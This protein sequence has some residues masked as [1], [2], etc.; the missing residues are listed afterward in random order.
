MVK[1][2]F[3]L[4]QAIGNLMT[5]RAKNL[6]IAIAVKNNKLNEKYIPLAI[7]F[8]E[9]E[10]N[11]YLAAEL[12][13]KTNNFNKAT[14]L[15]ASINLFWDAARTAQKG[16]NILK[17]IEY[18]DKSNMLNGSVLDLIKNPEE[19]IKHCIK[20]GWYSKAS[21]LCRLN[22][23]KRA[24]KFAKQAEK[25][26]DDLIKYK[27]INST[28]NH[29]KKEGKLKQAE[30]LCRKLGLYG[31]INQIYNEM[32]KPNNADYKCILGYDMFIKQF[33]EGVLM[34]GNTGNIYSTVG[35]IKNKIELCKKNKK[36]DFVKVL[37]KKKLILDKINKFCK[38]ATKYEDKSLLW[39]QRANNANSKPIKWFYNLLKN[40]TLNKTLDNYEQIGDYTFASKVCSE[41][42]NIE[43]ATFYKN[44]AETLNMDI[45]R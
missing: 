40:R 6:A 16:N 41:H 29:L 28:I 34:S 19:K 33:C 44:L 30:D 37:I 13:E 23:D 8:H 21:D 14:E 25:Q 10:G 2:T 27:D 7:K 5:E 20:K 12:Y 42:N 32:F 9:S 1:N 36:Y 3:D 17:A 35:D 39:K 11:D 24:D 43:K 45:N 26:K 18:S 22:N 38:K 15:Y 4:E 31:S